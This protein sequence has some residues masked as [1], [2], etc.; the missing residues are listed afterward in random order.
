MHMCVFYAMLCYAMPCYVM[1]C[2]V[3]LCYVV[4]SYLMLCFVC[5]HDMCINDSRNLVWPIP[6]LMKRPTFLWRS[7]A[8]IR[9]IPFWSFW[10]SWSALRSIMFIDMFSLL[11]HGSSWVPTILLNH[12]NMVSG[13]GVQNLGQFCLI[14]EKIDLKWLVCLEDQK[15]I[16]KI[17]RVCIDR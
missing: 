2:H 5:R 15:C 13:W 11:N 7:T 16:S 4:L 14:I 9:L 17:V 6:A 10:A 1:L 12:G 3:M 8:W